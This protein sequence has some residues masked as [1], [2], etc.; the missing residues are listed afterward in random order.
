MVFA[1]I[2]VCDKMDELDLI[3]LLFLT[4][5]GMVAVVV[6]PWVESDKNPNISK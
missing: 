5:T 6:E 2:G 1:V 4:E 3:N